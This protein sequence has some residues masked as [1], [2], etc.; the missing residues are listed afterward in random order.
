MMHNQT[1][2][3]R[4]ANEQPTSHLDDISGDEVNCLDGSDVAISTTQ[5]LR[6]FGAVLFQGRNGV[7]SISFLRAV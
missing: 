4:E 3:I 2:Y 1:R 6:H 7:F 5:D